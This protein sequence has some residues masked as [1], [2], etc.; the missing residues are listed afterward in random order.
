M[1]SAIAQAW[2][3]WMGARSVGVLAAIAFAVGIGSATAIYTVVNGV[4]L[5]PLPYA[6]SDRFV[7]LYSATFSQPKQRGAHAFPD[8]IEYQQRTRSFDVFGW[9]TPRSFNMM[10]GTQPEH[11]VG[12]AVTPSLAHNVGVNPAIGQWFVDESGVVISNALWRRL[13]SDPGIAG[14]PLTLDGK[15][16][17]IT[18]VMPAGF[19]LPVPGPGVERSRSDVWI[20]LDPLGKGQ[21]RSVGFNF[22]YARRK[23]GVTF[24][25]ADEDV[26]R[27]AAEIAALNP[28]AHPSYTARLDDL[29]QSVI[30]EIRP[31]L[32]LLVAAAGLLLLLT[33]ADVAGLLLARAVARARETAVRVALGASR[34]QL[35]LHYFLEGLFASLAGAIA[36]VGLSVLLV[37]LV[38]SIAADYVPRA[39]EIAIDWTVLAFALLAACLASGLASLAPLWQAVRTVPTDVLSAG[40]RA[41][42]TARSRRLSRALVVA[43]IALAFTLLTVSAILVVHLRGLGRVSPGFDPNNL[44]T[45][46]LTRVERSGTTTQARLQDQKRIITALESIPGVT[47]AAFSNQ[48]PLAGCCF[49]TSI[50]PEGRAGDLEK[51]ERTSFMA[52]SPGYFRTM[53]VPLRSG[54]VLDERDVREDQLNV[55]VND[56][57]VRV[58]WPG[59]NPLGAYGRIGGPSGSRFQI[60]GIVGDVKNDGLGQPTVPEVYLLAAMLAVS[61]MRFAVRSTLPAKNLL[62]EIRRTV[63]SVDPTQPIHNA[64]TMTEIITQSVSLPT[65]GSWMVGFFAL[66]A[67]LMATLGIYG[68]VSYS[69]RQDTV[70]IGTRMALGAIDRDLLAMI[71]GSGL[72]MAAAGI[73]IGSLGVAGAAWVLVRSFEITQLGVLPF[74]ASTGVVACVAALA[75]FFPA[76]RA[77]SLSPMVAIRN[78]PGSMW[79]STTQTLRQTLA[80]VS[81]AI[82]L[83]G[84]P[85]PPPAVDLLSEL[86][87]ASRRAASFAEAFQLALTTLR[88]RLDGTSVMLLERSGGEYRMMAQDPPA[89]GEGAAASL[90][91]PA[92]G[93]IV[94]RLRFYSYPLPI[95][96]ADLDGWL[97][98]ATA[99]GSPH[100]VEIAAL[101]EHHVALVIALR[102]RDEIPGLLVLGPP[103]RRAEYADDERNALRQCA[104]QLTLMIEN[105]RLTSR[106]VEQEKLRRDLALAAEVQRRLLPE[107]PP[108]REAAALAA[109]SL[110]A[111]SVGGD[112][113]DFLDLGDHRIGIALADIAGKGVPAA[114]IMA[115]VQA[116]L[117]IVAADGNIPLPDLAAK[118]NDLLHRS[119]GSNSYATFFYAQL[120]ERSRQ[121]RY[122]NAGHNPPYLVRAESE[123][124]SAEGPEILELKI[125]GT[126]IGLFP[127]MTYQEGSVDLQ[128][129]DVLVAFTD[130]VTE[131]LNTADEEF[132]EERLKN[133]LRGIVHLSA[134]EISAAIATELRSWIKNTAQ[135]D[136]LTFVVM[137]VA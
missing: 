81:R 73:A 68:V 10:F 14:R 4:L 46:Q 37:R 42:A 8:L 120:D 83:A 99:G 98:W 133:L 102:T 82:S 40:V 78:E 106:I 112:Y 11:V 90:V 25:Q 5:R 69:V 135:Y 130:G 58:Y 57:A 47:S 13:G 55:L 12:A 125:G 16:F 21:D 85:A 72:K 127:Q 136:D 71:L 117:R 59:Q 17:T 91:L 64:S 84:E 97:R 128:S 43:E 38:L 131:A 92:D 124:P 28:A 7:A 67:L 6:H 31:T 60:V 56:A 86:V 20:L 61:P 79:R 52:I 75:S 27:V 65:A 108:D 114:L 129:G 1:L 36:G 30:L 35:G 100:A 80:G 88:S 51:T 45:F 74:A 93:F 109:V 116:S 18:G 89:G 95:T 111:R 15:P 63:Q 119:T 53:Q 113:Y 110:P 3:S 39:D 105:A 76:W 101:K 54:R 24:A 23:P 9:F 94:R 107:R 137:K 70:E 103:A 87:A 33:C 2:R 134:A 50:Y 77:T 118:I 22:S 49:S 132:G 32:V 96:A 104:E 44:M 62:A 126:V 122:V 41:S 121:L 26:R 34:R 115:V 19:R 66:A 123:A 48:L 29:Q